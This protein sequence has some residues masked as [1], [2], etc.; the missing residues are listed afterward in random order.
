MTHL[1]DT[2]CCVQHL[3]HGPASNITTK[4]GAATPGDVVLCSIVVAELLY[5]A[6]RSTQKTQTLIQVQTFCRPFQSLVFDDR[7]ADQYG[8]IRAHLAG[9]GAPIGPNDL[10]IASIALAHGLTLVTRNTSEFS[11]VPGLMLENWQ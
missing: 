9:L 6:H 5:G 7:A 11:R 2:N 3:R 1:L 8:R 10:L 4:L